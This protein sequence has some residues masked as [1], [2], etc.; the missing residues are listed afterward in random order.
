MFPTKKDVGQKNH[1]YLKALA[2]RVLYLRALRGTGYPMEKWQM[3]AVEFEAMVM[4]HQFTEEQ[5]ILLQRKT[6]EMLSAFLKVSPM[7]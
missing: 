5:G 1:K 2:K 3:T 6:T 4:T 7:V